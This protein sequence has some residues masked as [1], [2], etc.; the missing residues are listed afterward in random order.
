MN[1]YFGQIDYDIAEDI[2]N[3]GGETFQIDGKHF[4]YCLS[5]TDE[6][7]IRITD[8]IDRMIPFSHEDIKSLR[9]ALK[10]MDKGFSRNLRR[11][12]RTKEQLE[13]DF[14]LYVAN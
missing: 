6:D 3:G 8:G 12:E 9:K 14:E 13:S 7:T 2:I 4:E 11:A 5:C 1:I 10:L